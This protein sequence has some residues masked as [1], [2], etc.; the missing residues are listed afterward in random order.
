MRDQRVL[1]EY[2]GID[3]PGLIWRG[4]RAHEQWLGEDVIAKMGMK[5]VM[6]FWA[7]RI[8]R[9]WIIGKPCEPELGGKA[10]L[11]QQI[12]GEGRITVGAPHRLPSQPGV[13]R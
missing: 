2:R 13:R 10:K 6:M 12:R 9:V 1:I 7:E 3:K 5:S 4:S 11:L 8:D